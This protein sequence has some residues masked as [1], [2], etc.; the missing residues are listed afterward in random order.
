[1]EKTSATKSKYIVALLRLPL[2]STLYLLVLGSPFSPSAATYNYGEVLQKSMWFYE[3][4]RSGALPANNRVEWRGSS[5]VHDGSD[6]GHDLSGGW[7]D[8]GDNMK[9]NFP[10]AS[11]VTLLA[12]GGLEFANGYL[13]IGQWG[14]LLNNLRW[15]TDYFIKCHTA[16]NELY[17]QIGVGM[18][19]HKWWGA[20]EVFP[21][22][23]PSFK[24]DA[25]HP[26][27]DLAAETAAALA[28][29]S[30]L[31]RATDPVY[32]DLCL[33]H[34]KQLFT[35][36]D[37]YRGLYH[38]AITDVVDFYKSWSGYNDELL[39]AALWLHIATGDRSYLD[40]AEK[41]Y[42]SLPKEPQSDTPKYKE[43]LS[44]DDKTY[45][46]YVLL[47]KLTNKPIYHT[48]TQR[49]LDWWCY[50]YTARKA[51]TTTWSSD[52]GIAYT[53]DGLAWVRQW[54]PIRYAANTAFAAC[55][56]TA[57]L[58]L[59]AA[60][61]TLYT[62]WARSQID[63]ALGSNALKRSFVCGFGSNP[64]VKPHHRSMHGPYL[65]DNGR[66]PVESRHTLFGALVGG[67]KQDGSYLDDRL[68]AVGNE[69]ATD[70]NAGF[71]SLLAWSVKTY[72]GTPLADFPQPAVRD[73]EYTVVAKINTP[74]DRF[75]EISATIQNKTTWPARRPEHL[76]I[77]YYIDLSEVIEA[78]IAPTEVVAEFKICHLCS[79]SLVMT[80]LQPISDSSTIYYTDIIL[81]GENIFPGGQSPYRRE[82][83]FRIGLPETAP[84]NVWNPGNDPSFKGLTTMSDTV[85]HTAIPAYENGILVWGTEID[86]RTF[87]PPFWNRPAFPQPAYSPSIWNRSLF[88]GID[89]NPVRYTPPQ[90]TSAQRL[91]IQVQPGRI[92]VHAHHDGQISLFRLDG[93]QLQSQSVCADAAAVLNV[94][95]S[96][97]Q[98]FIVEFTSDNKHES[99]IVTAV[100]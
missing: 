3:V 40:Y 47:A 10:M 35:F 80:A 11:S 45:G 16:P 46:C 21:N 41:G 98:T 64:P 97:T 4:Q 79:T 94:P 43:A 86:G 65:D 62:E 55:A 25:T 66:T 88:K 93:A 100:R 5:A 99:R 67:P 72:G 42:S 17:G 82:V 36:A 22:E 6:V 77:R 76:K 20:P 18:T 29:S 83:Q 75:T 1:M 54:G 9:F 58:D 73:T 56:Y 69:V 70:Y 44:W 7:Y 14:W 31:F 38:E 34:S 51:G 60:K 61:R 13:S 27:S 87:V 15:A 68:D 39:W 2:L 28:A 8:A 23:R 33:T 89:P 19:D 24:I 63:Y 95:Q 96:A 52:V 57:C 59:P 91:T 53:P 85:G 12:W 37:T 32:A 50:G 74:G 84:Q 78:G 71:S 30:I 26:G 48:D 92:V 49:W 90:K 81:D